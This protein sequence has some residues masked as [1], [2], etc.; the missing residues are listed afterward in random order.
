MACS[1]A[2]DLSSLEINSMPAFSAPIAVATAEIF[3]SISPRVQLS[4]VY[5]TRIPA[6]LI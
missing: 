1:V 4:G 3:L 6:D 5:T 2:R